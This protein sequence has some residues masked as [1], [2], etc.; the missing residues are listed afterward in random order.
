MPPGPVCVTAIKMGL[1]KGTRHGSLVGLGSGLMDFVYCTG[2]VFATSAALLLV[3]NFTRDFPIITL[4]FQLLVVLG[5]LIYGFTHLKPKKSVLDS[6]IEPLENRSKVIKFL[7]HKG[8][9]LLGVA[10][11]LANIANPT[12]L[13]SLAYVTMNIHKFGLIEN[14]TLGNL[15]FAIGFGVGNFLW[16]YCIVK[17]LVYYKPKMSDKFLLKIQRY[18]GV[19][20]IGF[21]TFLGY[22]ILELT[23]WSEI[24]RLIFAF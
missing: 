21:G 8:P 1:N 7:T 3:E 15:C 12:F 14:S 17:T 16:I 10:V 19:T 9:F 2:A 13:P 4:S 18:A 20:L 22:R 5:I 24:I 23:K 6:S 11:A